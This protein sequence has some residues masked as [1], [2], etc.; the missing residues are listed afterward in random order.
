MKKLLVAVLLVAVAAAPAIAADVVTYTQ[1]GTITFDH[2]GHGEKLGCAACHEGEPAQIA[3]VDK[4]SGHDLCL[5]CHK[6]M[7]KDGAAAPTK[8]GECHVK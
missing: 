7:S 6:T 5:A 3:I 2:A 4:K 1:K 8:C